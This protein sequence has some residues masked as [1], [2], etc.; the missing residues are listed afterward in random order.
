MKNELIYPVVSFVASLLVTVCA[1]PLLLRFCRMKG[2]YDLPNERKVHHNNVPRLGGV[3]FVPAM[4]AGLCA[5]LLLMSG[6]LDTLTL[7]TSS[8]VLFAGFFLIYLIG[9][10][11]DLFGLRATWKFAI[12]FIASLFLPLCGVEINHLYGFLGIGA[13]PVCVS[14]P[15]TVFVSLLIVNSINL[16]DGIDGLASGLSIMALSIFTVLFFRLNVIG[17]TLLS[18]GFLGSVVA[19]FHFNMFGDAERHTKTFMGDAGSLMLGYVLAYFSIKYAMYKPELLPVRESALFVSYTLL[20]LPTFDLI[21]VSLA[22]LHRG[23]A[24]FHPDKTHIHHKV[25]AAGCTM[26]QALLAILALYVVF[27]VL[28]CVLYKSGLLVE[29]IVLGD[30]LL[31]SAFHAFLNCR[32]RKRASGQEGGSQEGV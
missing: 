21:R 4:L 6:S 3:L 22:R 14:Y 11:D 16:I 17:Y 30:V 20:L 24:L 29:W 13:L 23:V 5:S 9:V 10:A 25:M 26:R 32:I 15:L 27:C 12:Q 1:M 28:N 31:F 8:M 2:L 19:F 18:C 7:K